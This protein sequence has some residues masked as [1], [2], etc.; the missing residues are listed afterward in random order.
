MNLQSLTTIPEQNR[1]IAAKP[2]D[3]ELFEAAGDL[4]QVMDT[5]NRNCSY[6]PCW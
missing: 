2:T 1:E 3:E 6:R 5:T 4:T